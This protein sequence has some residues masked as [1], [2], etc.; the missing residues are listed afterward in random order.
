MRRARYT[1]RS[2]PVLGLLG[3]RNI[4]ERVTVALIH[5]GG[6]WMV[7]KSLAHSSTPPRV[8]EVILKKNLGNVNSYYVNR[9]IVIK[10][11]YTLSQ[12]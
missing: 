9:I 3:L 6:T 11:T 12:N 4:F 2:G 1:D 8:E 7:S 10:N 5:T